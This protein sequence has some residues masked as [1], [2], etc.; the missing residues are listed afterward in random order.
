MIGTRFKVQGS[1]F[2][3]WRGFAIRANYISLARITDPR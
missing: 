3:C 2:V 1:S